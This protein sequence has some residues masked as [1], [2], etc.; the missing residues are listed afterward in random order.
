MWSELDTKEN[1]KIWKN[2]KTGKH[3]WPGKYFNRT[4]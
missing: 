4:E 2:Q 1:G 3:F